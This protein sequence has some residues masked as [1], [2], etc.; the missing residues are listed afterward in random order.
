MSATRG[1]T[2][3]EPGRA[4]YT[5]KRI[6][7]HVHWARTEGIG[8][9][10][11][12]D[13]LDPRERI[14]TAV[15]KWR[16]RGAHGVAPGMALPVYVV[17]LQRSGTNMLLR[18]LDAAPEVEVHNENDRRLF[19]RFRMRPDDVLLDVVARS[20]HRVVLVKPLCDSQRVD[21][22]LDLPTGTPGRAVWVV[23]DVDDRARSEV[24]KFG[25][26]NLAA[27]RRIAAGEADGD[28][29]AARLPAEAVEL[30]RSLGVDA[31][32]PD[33]GAALFWCLRNGL[34]F[35]LGLDARDDVLLLSYDDLV[36][37][38]EATMRQ[39]CGFIDFPWRPD[40]SAHVERRV[41]HGSR[42]L[43]IDPRVRELCDA[44]TARLEQVLERQRAGA[45]PAGKEQG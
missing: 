6:A 8:R 24:S 4:A 43:S 16:W 10:I 21:Q 23:R 20:R 12:E 38:P 35:D 1:E 31:L 18:G 40:L 34:F 39:L 42:R 22:L 3:R 45:D 37:D 5:A 17:G 14:G 30:V 11:E 28:W 26:S 19:H 44:M 29:Q 33:S 9:L 7:R 25:D 2:R 41:S 13:R 15:A 36:R 32:T 27:L